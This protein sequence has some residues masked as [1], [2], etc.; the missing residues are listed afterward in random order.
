MRRSD[1]LGVWQH[2]T[3]KWCKKSGCVNHAEDGCDGQCYGCRWTF[4]ANP[5]VRWNEVGRRRFNVIDQSPANR[6]AALERQEQEALARAA[7]Q[8]EANDE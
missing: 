3:Y 2:P 5:T 1:W 7:R 4:T 8:R 6:R